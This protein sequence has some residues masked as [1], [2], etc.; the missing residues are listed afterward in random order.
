MAFCLV[1]PIRNCEWRDHAGVSPR[2]SGDHTG[3][4]RRQSPIS[5]RYSSYHFGQSRRTTAQAQNRPARPPAITGHLNYNWDC[6]VEP[7]I[8]GIRRVA[9]LISY[10]PRPAAGFRDV[11]SRQSLTTRRG[12]ANLDL[13]FW[14]LVIPT[15]TVGMELGWPVTPSRQSGNHSRCVNETREPSD[16]VA[17]RSCTRTTRIQV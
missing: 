14:G 4:R 13:P 1:V 10:T 9:S 11:C 16:A 6:S 12:V 8:G 2:V 5:Y 15:S 17:P 3:C 7:V